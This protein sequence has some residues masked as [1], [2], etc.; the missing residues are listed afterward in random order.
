MGNLFW[1]IAIVLIALVVFGAILHLTKILIVLA[2]L[3]AI[4]IVI[5]NILNRK[6]Q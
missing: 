2:L 3:L 4:L 5:Y 6:K 1:I